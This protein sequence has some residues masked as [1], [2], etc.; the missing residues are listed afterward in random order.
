MKKIVLVFLL[1]SFLVG[2]FKVYNNNY[3]E[4]MEAIARLRGKSWEAK[5][6]IWIVDG[7]AVVIRSGESYQLKKNDVLEL[8]DIIITGEDSFLI[9]KFGYESKI[10]LFENSRLK[11]DELLLK[12]N[13]MY[14]PKKFSF[15][16]LMGSIF[17]DFTKG[18]EKL[19]IKGSKAT[20]DIKGTQFITTAGKDGSLRLAVLYGSV[21][22]NPESGAPIIVNNKEGTI[23]TNKGN[24]MP[25]DNYRWVKTINWEK[26]ADKVDVYLLGKKIDRFKQKAKNQISMQEEV[27][28]IKTFMSKF[29]LPKVDGAKAVLENLRTASKNTFKRESDINKALESRKKLETAL[30]KRRKLLD[31]L[32]H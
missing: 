14:G 28:K 32:G 16:L 13:E 8:D 15:I 25:V 3:I 24:A 22:L 10:K 30:E 11:I 17:S 2:A 31:E 1:G 12:E 26:A 7:R 23:V 9:I 27:T 18:I 6:H 29:S 20:L 5:I 4:I 21:K 19:K